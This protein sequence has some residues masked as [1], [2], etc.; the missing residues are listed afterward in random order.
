MP[1]T[2][3]AHRANS[4]FMEL[5]WKIR[6]SLYADSLRYKLIQKI[7]VMYSNNCTQLEVYTVLMIRTCTAVGC[8]YYEFELL[9]ARSYGMQSDRRVWRRPCKLRGAPGGARR[10]TCRRRAVSR[11]ETACRS[12]SSSQYFKLALIAAYCRTCTNHCGCNHFNYV[13]LL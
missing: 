3:A 4:Y 11:D 8:N 5:Y 9:A 13:Q 2:R 10:N 6:S 12:G 1:K 7:Y